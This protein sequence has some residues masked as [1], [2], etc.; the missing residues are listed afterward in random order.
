MKPSRRGIQDQV[1][2]QGDRVGYKLTTVS[3]SGMFNNVLE[4]Y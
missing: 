1:N 3:P 2:V 4:F